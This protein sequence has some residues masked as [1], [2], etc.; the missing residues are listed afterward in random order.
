MTGQSVRERQQV[1][2]GFLSRVK[3]LHTHLLRERGGKMPFECTTEAFNCCLENGEGIC[4][5]KGLRGERW[6]TLTSSL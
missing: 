3:K 2:T 5:V 6:G 4:N 1:I